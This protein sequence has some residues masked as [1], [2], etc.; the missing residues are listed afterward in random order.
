MSRDWLGSAPRQ[1][2]FRADPALPQG[3]YRVTTSSYTGSGFDRGHNTPSADRTKSEE[4][5][6]ATFLM[7]NIIPQAPK[8]NQ[9][10]WANLEDYTR[11]LVG[12]GMEVYVVMGSLTPSGWPLRS[13]SG[14]MENSSHGTKPAQRVYHITTS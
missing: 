13:R 7:M 6:S 4:D 5:N 3:W 11:D 2:N 14:N 9:E 8:N 10:T 12:D 1:N